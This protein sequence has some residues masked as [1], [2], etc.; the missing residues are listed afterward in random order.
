MLSLLSARGIALIADVG[1]RTCDL[2]GL[3]RME[4]LRD[5]GLE[6]LRLDY[7]FSAQRVA[8]LSGVFRIVVNASTV[9]PDEIASWREAGADVTRFA[10]CHNFYPKPYTGLALED[11][12]RTNL[13][14]AALGFEIMAFVPG[15]ANVRGP[16]FEGLPT[17]EAQRGRASKVALNMLELAHGA[18]CDI[19][20]VGDPDLSEAGWAQFAQ[21]SAGYVDMPCQ[22][23]PGYSYLLGQV[24]HDRP[25]S[26][27][28]IFRSQESRTSLKPDSVSTDAG[29]GL[30]R[31]AGSIA[32][33]N[34]GYGRYEGEFEIARVDLPG[35]ERMNVVGHIAPEAMEL[36]PFVKR[37]FGVRFV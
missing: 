7:G 11:V 35:D 28:L 1:P 3:E 30:P 15:D 21:I 8:E 12:A 29:A 16:V 36:L 33:S 2:L 6:Y 17:V 27:A 32:V 20:L 14:L 18:D 10:A 26:S 34:S 25:D 5:L 23:D 4:D 31:K 24:H 19:V 9:S 13:R 22:L 37:G